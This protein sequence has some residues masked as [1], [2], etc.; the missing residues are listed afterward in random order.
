MAG[1]TR[2]T[3]SYSSFSGSF[4]ASTVCF[5]TPTANECINQA[6][7]GY[8]DARAAHDMLVD[9]GWIA[10]PKQPVDNYKYR[11]NVEGKAISPN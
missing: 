2:G 8:E 6:R 7:H 4:V 3:R 1:G 5:T 11:W 10:K 9:A